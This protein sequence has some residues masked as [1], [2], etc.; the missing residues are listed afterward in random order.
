[1]TQR[2][3]RFA[4]GGKEIYKATKGGKGMKWL[5][6]YPERCVGCESCMLTCSKTW[7]KEEDKELSRIQVSSSKSGYAINVC[8]QCGECIDYCPTLA[9]K[10]DNSG[11]VRIDESKCVGCLMCAGFCPTESMFVVEKREKPFKCIACGICSKECPSEAL[12]LKQD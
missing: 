9:I 1:M 3:F 10:R 11:V 4:Q 2:H 12:E 5:A 8:N 6:T 7:F